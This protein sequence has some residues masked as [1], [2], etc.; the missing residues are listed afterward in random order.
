VDLYYC[1]GMTKLAHKNYRPDIDGLRAVAVTLV[2]LGHAFPQYVPGGFIGVD[3]FFVISGYLITGI[4]RD[5]IESRSFSVANFYER[6]IR[7]IFPALIAV[8]LAV[9]IA[10]WLILT[11]NEF[12]SLGKQ[13]VAGAGFSSNVL[14]Y[15]E[16]G[17]FD[18][19]AQTKPL[20]HLWSLGIEEQFYLVWPLL[21]L[22]FSRWRIAPTFP[23]VLI[24]ACSF[25]A[26][27]VIVR[28]DPEAAFYL[29]L[30]RAWELAA[31][32]LIAIKNPM[33]LISV[34]IQNMLGLASLTTIAVTTACYS[35]TTTYPGI[36]AVAPAV[37]ASTLIMTK[38]SR[39]NRFLS[40]RLAVA[41]GLISYP[42]Y[43]WHWPLLTMATIF[44]ASFLRLAECGL[45]V[46]ASLVLSWLTY[47]YVERPIRFA[48][49][50]R[51]QLAFL[52]TSMAVT[53]SIGAL[54]IINGFAF[55]I[56]EI[57]REATTMAVSR[58][59]MRYG[60]CHISASTEPFFETNCV[61]ANK[62]PLV[63]I[64]GDSTAGMLA[65]GLRQIQKERFGLAQFTVNSCLPVFTSLAESVPYCTETNRVILSK[66]TISRPDIVLLHAAWNSQ[67]TAEDLR[68]TIDALRRIGIG[69]IIMIGPVPNWNAPLPR[70][71]FQY[72]NAHH[73]LIPQ[74]MS[75]HLLRTPPDDE[76]KKNSRHT[77][78][79][80]FLGL[81]RP[82]RY[83]RLLNESW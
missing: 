68:P 61:D 73:V 33:A 48:R 76:F 74:R 6:R 64:W 20:L 45:V 59:F 40:N 28:S 19:A 56:P 23:L 80:L 22:T 66:V 3:I 2:V 35:S 37:A 71:M 11:P 7:R 18:A 43:L 31:G 42:L 77:C 82:L 10:G 26:N 57:I 1:A 83:R 52:V 5:D 75:E 78:Y 9:F 44:K 32:A 15:S 17:Y 12:I 65:A 53:A 29:P 36:A 30:T 39:I 46:A 70:L 8:L 27:I 21:L 54:A 50:N 41:V 81:E 79:W 13:I 49:R 63:L 14:L 58:D 24:L 62:H 38:A 69:Q 25:L 47:I 4:I 67:L 16:G 60:E 55:R 72:F 51:W 34:G